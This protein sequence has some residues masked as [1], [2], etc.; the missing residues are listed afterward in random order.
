MNEAEVA[1]KTNSLLYLLNKDKEIAE[2]GILFCVSVFP[3]GVL[4]LATPYF[5][6]EGG[7]N[8]LPLVLILSLVA[9]AF[10]F[11]LWITLFIVSI[12]NLKS[13]KIEESYRRLIYIFCATNVSVLFVLTTL[14]FSV[15]RIWIHI[16]QIFFLSILFLLLKNTP[17]AFSKFFFLLVFCY[18]IAPFFVIFFKS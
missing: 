2:I 1:G 3:A 7:L 17:S 6:Q 14:M 12:V 10:F 5:F 11:V 4:L 18:L 13:S 16:V 8:D 15:E 9:S